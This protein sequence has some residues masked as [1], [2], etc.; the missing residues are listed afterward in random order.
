MKLRA[1][2]KDVAREAKVS[3]ATISYVLNGKGNISEETKA[4]IYA[5]MEKLNY[6]PNLSARGL[7]QNTSKL[8]GVV[9]PQTEPGERLIFNNSFY[10]EVIGAIEYTARMQ[11]YHVLISATDANES[12]F[13]LARQRNL[14]GIIVI[15]AYPDQFYL[16]VKKTQIPIVLIDSY[17][18]DHY[19]HSIQIND[20][21]GG[22]IATKY[23]LDKGHRNIGIFTGKIKEGGV[24]KKRYDGYVDALNEYGIPVNPEFIFEETV[25]FD[26]GLKLAD[27]LLDKKTDITAIFCIADIL[28][29]G[30]MKGL[31]NRGVKIP[32]DISIIG[33]DDLIVS[34]YFSPS[35]TT[36]HQDIAKKGE[37][38]VRLLLNTINDAQKGKQEI[39][40]PLSLVE[41]ESVKKI[42]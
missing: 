28:A 20:R 26:S 25:D 22:Y 39:I 8:I 30:A 12:Y 13:N 5:A 9:I 32:D 11:G 40:L 6:I 27:R 35:L 16:D 15:G 2:I 14:D 4:R 41:R 37:E 36:V 18:E 10:S 3:P 38:A 1:T 42:N 34:R 23:L 21:Y 19:F 31:L 33:F 17:F 29:I 24:V 7:V